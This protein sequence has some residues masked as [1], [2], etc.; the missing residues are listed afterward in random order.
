MPGSAPQ[1]RGWLLLQ[2]PGPWPIDA[3]AGSGIDPP[4]LQALTK[5]A[6][7]AEVRVLLVRRPGRTSRDDARRWILCR[8]GGGAVD[9]PWA[10]D[11]DLWA[12]VEAL[13]ANPVAEQFPGGHPRDEMQILV[14][15]HGVHDTCCA[16]R[17]RPVAAALAEH[18]PDRVWECSHV[19]GDRFAPNVVLVPDGFYYGNLDPDTAV[20]VVR[21]HLRG[22]VDAT[23]L[24]GMAAF[25]P[26][27]QAAVVAA[28]QLM[29][30]LPPAAVRPL[31][32]DQ[33]GPHDNHGSQTTVELAVEGTPERRLRIEIESVRRPPAKLTCRAIRETPATEYRTATVVVLPPTRAPES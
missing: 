13:D 18:W 12:A 15:A 17:G 16:I 25:R 14:C 32:V 6:A 29:G 20:E 11:R 9:G 3:I 30:P 27:V 19:G 26:P 8:P 4:I 24:R 28:Y 1:A 5:A 21:R 10:D 2:H 23:W 22:E 31:S 7:R 33:V